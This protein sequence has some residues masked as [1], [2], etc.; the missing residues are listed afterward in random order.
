MLR[1]FGGRSIVRISDV[2]D[3]M[4]VGLDDVRQDTMDGGPGLW[5][6]YE[7]RWEISRE[8][9]YRT[10][11][12][13]TGVR[14]KPYQTR[15]RRG[16]ERVY[17]A[18][19]RSIY[20]RHGKKFHPE[21]ELLRWI[22]GRELLYPSLAQWSPFRIYQPNKRH[23]IV[24]TELDYAKR[25]GKRRRI[26]RRLGGGRH[27]ARPLL[28]IEG[29]SLKDLRRVVLKYVAAHE[30]GLTMKLADASSVIASAGGRR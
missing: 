12:R 15:R 3:L 11:G 25:L 5:K 13:H 26:P 8:K 10:K 2:L 28:K 21:R 19:K 16:G 1:F 30:K 14:W 17:V 9:M 27:P 6:R 18:I 22:R 4:A 7:P 29:D 23:L 20:A 24:G